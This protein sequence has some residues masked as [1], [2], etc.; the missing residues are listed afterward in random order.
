MHSFTHPRS[1]REIFNAFFTHLRD[2]SRST[3][4]KILYTAGSEVT[5][6]TYRRIMTRDVCM[7]SPNPRYIKFPARVG[8]VGRGPG[9]DL[10][11][12]SVGRAVGA[13]V[14]SRCFSFVSLSFLFRFGSGRV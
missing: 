2:G 6:C 14:R 9:T 11:G 4:R 8:A 13:T 1:V 12:R 5:V 10:D 7:E 3:T